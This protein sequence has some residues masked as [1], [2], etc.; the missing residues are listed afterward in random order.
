MMLNVPEIFGSGGVKDIRISLLCLIIESRCHL[1]NFSCSIEQVFLC[2]K[3]VE[4]AVGENM[5]KYMLELIIFLQCNG[6]IYD[7]LDGIPMFTVS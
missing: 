1:P 6:D 2:L 4:D 7:I 5:E 3:P